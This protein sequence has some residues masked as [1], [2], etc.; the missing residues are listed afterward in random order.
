MTHADF[1]I[2]MADI[3]GSRNYDQLA[4]ATM[5]AKLTDQINK[6][7]A[8]LILSPLTV[9]LGDE[10]QAVCKNEEASVQLVYEIEKQMF[11]RGYPCYLRYIVYQGPIDTALNPDIAHGMLGE[12]LSKAR[13]ILI[14]EK[15]NHFNFRLKNENRSAFLQT[16]F[17]PFDDFRTLAENKNQNIL[18]DLVFTELGDREIGDRHGKTTSQVWKYRRNWRTNTYRSLVKIIK[19]RLYQC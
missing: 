14:S 16:L 7:Q 3:I 10:F 8:A 17:K 2:L 18:E 4:I 12:G 1:H 19:R 11:L 13:E 15:R 5:L 9:T 6:E